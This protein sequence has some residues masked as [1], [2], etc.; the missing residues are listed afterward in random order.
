MYALDGSMYGADRSMYGNHRTDVRAAPRFDGSMYGVCQLVC[1]ISIRD[2]R[3][4][5]PAVKR[6]LA[7]KPGSMYGFCQSD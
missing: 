6:V 4:P 3:G 7:T 5:N 1:Q 2:E